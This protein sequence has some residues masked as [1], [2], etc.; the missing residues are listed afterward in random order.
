MPQRMLAKIW[1]RFFHGSLGVSEGMPGFFSASFLL[2][3]QQSHQF[4][5]DPTKQSL[6]MGETVGVEVEKNKAACRF[7]VFL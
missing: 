6:N 7:Y 3:P 1:E 4:C 5:G 2:K